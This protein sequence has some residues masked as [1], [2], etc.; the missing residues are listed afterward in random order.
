M[1]AARQVFLRQRRRMQVD[2]GQ[3]VVAGLSVFSVRYAGSNKDYHQL[4]LDLRIP[5]ILQGPNHNLKG[6][7]DAQDVSCE[8]LQ[9]RSFPN[10]L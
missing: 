7:L 1:R 9:S 2:K 4:E 5:D 6:H 8:G 10:N 3:G